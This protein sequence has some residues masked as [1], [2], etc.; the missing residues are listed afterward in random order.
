MPEYR[1][2]RDSPQDNFGK[3]RTDIQ[4]FGGGYGNGKTAAAV[5]QKIIKVA[6][7][8]PGCNILVARSTYPKLNDTIRKEFILWCPKS[9]IKSFPLSKNSSNT[10]EMKNGSM[11]N[12]RYIAQQG[13]AASEGEQT[14]SNL[15][16]ATYDMI[17]VDQ[18]EDPEIVEKDFDDLL[19]RL[20]GSAKYVGSDPTM[21]LIG[22]QWF[23]ITLNPTRNWAYRR[24]IKP[25]HLYLKTGMVE[26]GL[27]CARE[28]RDKNGLP[29]PNADQPVLGSD[30]KP[31]LLMSLVEG[32]TY[33]NAHN[34]TDRFLQRLESAYRGQMRD[35][36]LYGEWASY[37]GLVHPSFTE[38]DH[39]LPREELAE[40]YNDL[41]AAGWIPDFIEAYDFGIVVPSCYLLAYTDRFKNVFVCDGFYIPEQDCKL[42]KQQELIWQIRN[43][44]GYEGGNI[45]ADPQLFK[46]TQVQKNTRAKTLAS[47]FGEGKNGVAMRAADNEVL[48]GITKTNVYLNVDERHRHPIHGSF[49]APHIFFAQELQWIADEFNSYY[50]KTDPSGK[51]V[52]E[53]VEKNDHAM[54]TIKYMLSKQ[55]DLASRIAK[56]KNRAYLTQW[57]ERPDGY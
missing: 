39:M 34:L 32:S 15:L 46:K 51:R 35:R 22:P 48:R 53:P 8:Y 25:Y 18:I 13:K 31:I 26:E 3:L 10:C 37:E 16:S 57:Q 52:D 38:L 47:L 30:G 36:Y 17:V 2:V 21:P 7:D 40:F 55:P 50:W 9:A 42:D 4:V 19:G 41:V 28:P 43:E 6:K 12:F 20:R 11:I 49:G 5:V 1:V 45:R 33:T 27:L 23:I 24:I 56:V 44:W 14:T 29:N 54:N